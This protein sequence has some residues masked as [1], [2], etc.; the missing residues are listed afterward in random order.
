MGLAQQPLELVGHIEQRTRMVRAVGLRRF[1]PVCALLATLLFGQ[2]ELR[3]SQAGAPEDHT[4]EYRVKAAFLLNFTKF[5]EWPESAF[6]DPKSSLSICIL[7]AD[8]FGRIL[9]QTLVGEV[10]NSRK[11]VV[12]RIQ[13]APPLKACQVL[14]VGKL[15]EDIAK[16]L[17]TVGPGVLTVGEDRGF[18]RGGGMICFLI[19]A[20]RVRFDINQTA[21]ETGGLKLSSK[22][23][24]VARQVHGKP[25]E[26]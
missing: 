16:T 13:S 22:L 21:A 5:T 19:E 4:L 24:K 17:A 18:I 20:G 8:P 12:Q 10:V 9:D 1:L 25:P 26:Q 7:G 23:L 14:F 6:G 11:V 15:E 3:C 2:G